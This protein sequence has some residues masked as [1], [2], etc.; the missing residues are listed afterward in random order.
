VQ[1][2]DKYAELLEKKEKL[3]EQLDREIEKT[4]REII[5]F[6]KREGLDTI[7]GTKAKVR[8]VISKRPVFPL[9]GDDRREELKEVLK[10]HGLWEQVADIDTY[11]LSKLIRD[12]A[13]PV[14]VEEEIKKYQW[15]EKIEKVYL[16]KLRENEKRAF[17]I[18]DEE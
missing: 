13:L 11:K 3:L 6:A 17:G 9:K 4:K 12:G 10:K 15:E 18:E 14:D 5:D 8:V 1:L 2:V 7:Y 16:N